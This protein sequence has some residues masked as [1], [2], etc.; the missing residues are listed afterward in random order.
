MYTIVYNC[1]QYISYLVLHTQN[2]QQLQRTVSVRSTLTVRIQNDTA[3]AARI[4]YR[5][6]LHVLRASQVYDTSLDYFIEITSKR[7]KT[8]ICTPLSDP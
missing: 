3:R 1:I 5:I 2:A 8:I 7:F 6:I 4:K